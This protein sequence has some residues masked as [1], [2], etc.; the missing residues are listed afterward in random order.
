MFSYVRFTSSTKP[1][2]L[3]DS[4]AHS[5]FFPLRKLITNPNP[6]FKQ[7]FKTMPVWREEKCFDSPQILKYKTRS[8]NFCL[9][10]QTCAPLGNLGIIS[11]LDTLIRQARPGRIERGR[12]AKAKGGVWKM[13]M[14]VVVQWNALPLAAGGVHCRPKALPHGSVHRVCGS[15]WA[16]SAQACLH[17]ESESEES[18]ELEPLLLLSDLFSLSSASSSSSSSFWKKK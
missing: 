8:F 3:W 16:R 14:D 13:W 4:L 10:I 5:S 6:L 9:K 7:G 11:V 1:T 15:L 12:G 2:K 17:S 18:S